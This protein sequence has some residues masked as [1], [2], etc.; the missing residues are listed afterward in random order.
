MTN[1]PQAVTV[2]SLPVISYQEQR[3]ITTDLLAQCYGAKAKNLRDNFAN[4][5]ERFTLG[6]HYFKLEGEEL[7]QFKQFHCT[8]NL[9]SVEISPRTRN[10]TLWTERGA[11]RHAKMLDTDQAWDVFE[12]LEDAYFGAAPKAD[13]D[14]SA[15]T[16]TPS[17]R[18]LLSE[19]VHA[20][21]EGQPPEAHGKA[22]SEIWSRLHRKFRVAKYEQ[23]PRTQ[24][25]DAIA[26]VQ[27]MA[28]KALGQ[29][30]PPAE[31]GE[32][33]RAQLA[34][35]ALHQSRFLVCFNKDG[36]MQF[37]EVERDAIVVTGEQVASIISEP[38]VVPG[39]RLPDVIENAAKRLRR[40][41]VSPRFLENLSN[42]TEK[43]S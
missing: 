11:A 6:K 29:S 12:K 24:L 9:G 2:E 22:I 21:L 5:E 19:F 27:Q 36:L 3:V 42:P 23:L 25:K 18:Q 20:K 15:D 30:L 40:I 38:G 17:E 43:A 1:L 39:E 13:S 33:G 32:T 4:N 37:R 7:K 8:E 35:E 31:I 26:Y 41:G 28:V 10:L 34:R 14:E 16:L